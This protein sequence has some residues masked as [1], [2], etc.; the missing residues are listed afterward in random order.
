M[1]H[2]VRSMMIPLVVWGLIGAG[3]ALIGWQLFGYTPPA[4]QSVAL[5]ASVDD[6]TIVSREFADDATTVPAVPD[7]VVVYVSGE[8]QAPGLYTVP[9]TWRIGQVVAH[10]GGLTDVADVA[11]VNLAEPIHD[12]MHVH[13]PAL[14]GSADSSVVPLLPGTIVQTGRV[15]I[16]Q[17]SQGE[18]EALPGIGPSL[19]QRIVAYRETHGPFTNLESLAAV[20]GIGPKLL[21]DLRDSVIFH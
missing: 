15:A 13:M 18:L 20:P 19:A 4:T 17:A 3:V 7:A 9:A 10:A 11:G 8:V 21:A 2:R 5:P 14:S 1:Q 12:A 6:A 16:N